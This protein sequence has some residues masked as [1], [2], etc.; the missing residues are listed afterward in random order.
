MLRRLICLA[1]LPTLLTILSLGRCCGPSVL[2]TSMSASEPFPWPEPLQSMRSWR[3]VARVR[4]QPRPRPLPVPTRG[5]GLKPVWEVERTRWG[6]SEAGALTVSPNRRAT[7]SLKG[8]VMRAFAAE[9]GEMGALEEGGYSLDDA[10]LPRGPR[11][12]KE[13]EGGDF[14]GC[15]PRDGGGSEDK[16]EGRGGKL[17][18]GAGERLLL[19]VVVIVEVAVAMLDSRRGLLLR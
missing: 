3:A 12:E 16:A 1:V 15:L 13:G 11:G 9:G 6:E 8:M 2:R 14:K 4:V 5:S 7:L 19:V 17:P 18:R 10:R